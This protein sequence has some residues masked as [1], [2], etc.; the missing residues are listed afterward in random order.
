M[1]MEVH[2]FERESKIA[3]TLLTEVARQR[4]EPAA[5]MFRRAAAY[6][7]E[8]YAMWVYDSRR[9]NRLDERVKDL[10]RRLEEESKHHQWFK[11]RWAEMQQQC[12]CLADELEAAKKRKGK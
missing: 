5:L 1:V 4:D 6:C 8:I 11:E 7:S 10:E 12:Q 3:Q 2:E 9:A